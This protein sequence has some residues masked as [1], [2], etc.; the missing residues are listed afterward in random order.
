MYTTGASFRA[1]AEAAQR[2]FRVGV[3]HAGWETYGHCLDSRGVDQGLNFVHPL[4]R[5]AAERRAEAGKGVERG[6]TFQNMLASQALCFNLFA[7]LAASPEGLDLASALLA[8]WVPTLARV[9]R[10]D[11]EYT[12]LWEIFQDQRGK[13]GVDC[14]VLIG[15]EQ[16]N[17]QPGVLVV[18]TKFVEPAFSCCGHRKPDARDPCSNDVILGADFSGCRYVSRNRFLYWQR[19]VETRALRLPL[20]VGSRCPFGGPLWQIWV[21]HT[22]AHALAA[23]FQ[24]THAV[25]AVCAP[26]EK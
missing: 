16:Q 26:R 1:L 7:P 20:A 23:R 5:T 11:I 15:F 12:P 6:R 4:A 25:Y 2:R 8:P 24:A 14:D 17:G 21:N 3:L 9:C 13:A 19:C 10:I 18:E 22:L